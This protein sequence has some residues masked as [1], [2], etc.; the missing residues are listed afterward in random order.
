[1][2]EGSILKVGWMGNS[3]G[4][5]TRIPVRGLTDASR[6]E[7]AMA[8]PI[9]ETSP[10]AASGTILIRNLEVL[11]E[12]SPELSDKFGSMTD[13]DRD[14]EF[15]D[16][17]FEIRTAKNGQLT[18]VALNGDA[19]IPLHSTY[20]PDREA[21]DQV[22]G[23]LKDDRRNYFVQLGFGLGYALEKL[24]EEVDEKTKILVVEPH[25]ASFRQA[26][27]ARDLTGILSDP[28][29]V[30]VFGTRI[31]D[32]L[33][34]FMKRYH[35][36]DCRG[37]GFM[38]HAGRTN[39]PSGDFWHSFLERLKAL[40]V[41]SGG[42]LQTLMTMAWQY[43]KNTMMSIGKVADH[44]PV[45]TLFNVFDGKPALIV[46]AGPSL[47]KNI[48]QIAELRDKV[49]LIAVDTTLRPLLKKGIEPDLVCTGDPQEANWRHLRGTETTRA[50][51]VAEPMTH[52]SSLQHF[53][54][55]L[56]IASYGDKVMSWVSKFIP[57]VGYVMCWGSV[58]TMA[59]DLARKMGC[60]PIVFVGQDLSFPGDRTY[61]K[62]TYFEEEDNLDLSVEAF[63]KR[64]STYKLTDI[65]GEP[66]K[67]NRQMFA[68]KEWFRTEFGRT[69]VRVVNATEGGILK[70][71]CE[72]M[73]LSEAAESFMTEEFDAY[74]VII[75]AASNFEGYELDPL[76]R[77]LFEMIGSIKKAVEICEVGVNRIR[78]AVNA[79]ETMDNLPPTWCLQVIKDLDDLRFKLKAED[80]MATFLETAN[81]TGVLNFHRAFK[82]VNHAR[83]N[84]VTFSKALDLYTNLFM[85]TA[86]TGRG[87]LPFFVNG[88]RILADRE[89]AGT[90]NPEEL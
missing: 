10:Q 79:A 18:M 32:G 41:T 2:E 15:P 19:E 65:Y 14:E 22:R 90:I 59:F 42:N 72:I 46:S 3:A 52:Y 84:R 13:E 20:D 85:S 55:R 33:A 26:L 68:Y 38:E 76:R 34:A 24:L 11:R 45:R 49:V 60:D 63:E 64:Q 27:A 50:H 48:D 75:D 70:E 47:E 67:T 4:G 74:E 43:Q 30:L 87:V 16:L 8:H 5:D 9:V 57:E 6:K 44:P 1:M 89:D 71:N 61:V 62:G 17:S 28:R 83:F 80:S 12:Y 31:E 73:T 77:G 78:E 54:S 82:D 29:T 51:L 58:A 81:Q 56:F 23:V 25:F 86:R 7:S 36:A 40:M 21:D 69:D 37:V 88:F 35:L 66:V 53:T 39:L